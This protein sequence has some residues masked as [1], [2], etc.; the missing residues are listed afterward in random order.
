M[1]VMTTNDGMLRGIL[2]VPY[3]CDAEVPVWDFFFIRSDGTTVRFHT[4]YSNNKVEVANVDAAH[5]HEMPLPPHNGKGRSDGRGTYKRQTIGNYEQIERSSQTDRGGGDRGGGGGSGVADP[6][7]QDAPP[8]PGLGNDEWDGRGGWY[9]AWTRTG[10]D[11]WNA[12]QDWRTT[13]GWQDWGSG[14]QRQDHGA[15]SS[16]REGNW[17]Q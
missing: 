13:H 17:W 3:G 12:W 9:C 15:A 10:G 5:P 6:M 4:N 14:W 8:P 16:S 7:V 2:A 11:A 1:E